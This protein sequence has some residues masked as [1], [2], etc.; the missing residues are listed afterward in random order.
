MLLTDTAGNSVR[1]TEVGNA[2]LGVAT[3]VGV[4][5]TGSISI[6]YGAGANQMAQV[7]IPS[8]FASKLGASIVP[9]QSVATLDVTTAAGASNAIRIIDE[10]LSEVSRVRGE[11][12]SFQKDFLESNV[13]SLGIARE[14]MIATHSQIRDVDIAEEMT[15]NVRL[16]ILQQSGLA[17]LAQANHV[18]QSVLQLLQDT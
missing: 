10:A 5:E 13:R 11:L 7:S 18:P 12:G 2:G 3:Q 15:E 8:L 9:G 4:L 1:L 16:Q 6:Q 14:N 17:V